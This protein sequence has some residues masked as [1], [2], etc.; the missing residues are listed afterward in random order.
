MESN[1]IAH[2]MPYAQNVDTALDVKRIV[3]KAGAEPSGRSAS[4]TSRWRQRGGRFVTGG[5]GAAG[6]D[7]IP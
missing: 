5:I 7:E 1:I 2:G 3:R 6:P 4:V